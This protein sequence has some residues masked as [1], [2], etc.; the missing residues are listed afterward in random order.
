MTKQ[1]LEQICQD[2]IDNN[3]DEYTFKEYVSP[4]FLFDNTNAEDEW[5]YDGWQYDWYLHFMYKEVKFTAYGSG[6]IGKT[7]IERTINEELE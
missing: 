1:E 2:L 5:D 3:K 4:K 7:R 6:Y